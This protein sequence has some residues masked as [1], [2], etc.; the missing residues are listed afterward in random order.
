M[1]ACNACHN[2]TTG[3]DATFSRRSVGV[4]DENSDTSVVQAWYNYSSAAT[5]KIIRSKLFVNPSDV[6]MYDSNICIAC[7]S[8]KAAGDLIKQTTISNGSAV[9][10]S[11]PSIVCR[12]GD[13]TTGLT[14]PFWANVNFIDPHGMGSANLMIPD[15]LRAGYEYRTGNT[16]TSTNHS[17]IGIGSQGPCVGCHMSSPKKHL[18]SPVSSASNGVITA[19]TTTL[20]SSCHGVN[21][22]AF[23]INNAG[24]L[25][26]KKEG[27]QAALA[28]ITAQLAAK[29]IYYNTAI[30]PYFFTSAVPASQTFA[31]RTVN[32]NINGTFQGAN[33]MG[34]AFNLRLLQSDAGWVHNGTTAKRLLYDTIDYLDDGLQNNTVST[35]IQNLGIDQAT[36]DKAAEYIGTRP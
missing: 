12:L 9:C 18:F 14:G 33:L 7:H 15:A 29:G 19:I 30:P 21:G 11:L 13:A 24:V 1:I 2:N 23:L 27:Y 28:V 34:A 31:T 6:N 5:K 25:E 32:W 22:P 17:G 8:G 35:A 3:F 26:T 4:L 20:C 36:K 10:S 16:S